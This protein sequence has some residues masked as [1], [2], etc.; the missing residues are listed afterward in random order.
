MLEKLGYDKKSLGSEGFSD[1]EDRLWDK[2]GVEEKPA[3]AQLKGGRVKGFAALNELAKAQETADKK[4]KRNMKKAIERLAAD[5][6]IGVPTLTDII[7][8]MK[9]P[10]RDPRE[11][12]PEVIF[13]HPSQLRTREFLARILEK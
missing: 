10:G 12:A 6:D 13:T 8:E 9:K 7:E 3:K 5:L 2:Y 1:I 4:P 11:D